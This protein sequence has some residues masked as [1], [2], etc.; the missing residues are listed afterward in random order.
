[1]IDSQQQQQ[2]KKETLQSIV[3][4]WQSDSNSNPIG[5]MKAAWKQLN[6]NGFIYYL[7]IIY[8]L[9][10]CWWVKEYTKKRKI[11]L[12]RTTKRLWQKKRRRENRK[13]E[14]PLL[15]LNGVINLIWG[16]FFVVLLS[17]KW[18]KSIVRK[19]YGSIVCLVCYGLWGWIGGDC[20]AREIDGKCLLLSLKW[21]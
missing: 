3:I 2:R 15:T 9:V 6:G 21:R 12:T 7:R 11:N 4:Q 5:K 16:F 19:M 20:D 1:M 8:H 17:S 18:F 14:M 10:I 13:W